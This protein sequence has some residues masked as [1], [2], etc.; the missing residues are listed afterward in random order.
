MPK[1]RQA[2]VQMVR[3]SICPTAPVDSVV[4]PIRIEKRSAEELF[5]TVAMAQL[6]SQFEDIAHIDNRSSSL[7]IIGSTVL[8]IT[9]GFLTIDRAV[10]MS[11]DTVRYALA[12]G[13][14]C[15]VLLAA[16]YVWSFKIS[17]WDTRPD[18]EQWREETLGREEETMHRWL[19][20][21]CVEAYSNNEPFIEKKA[22]KAGLAVWCL[23]GEVFC[24]SV[25]V[26]APLFL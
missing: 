22:H 8:P 19:G 23:G 24:L 11:E 3:R 16:F 10:L 1:I 2:L 26:L 9:A 7:F 15:Y 21:G 4:S 6:E 20:D 13:F 18:M 5:C 12:G 25:A 17:G 14:A